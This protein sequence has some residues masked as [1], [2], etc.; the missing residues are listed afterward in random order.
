MKFIFR[1]GKRLLKVVFTQSSCDE[2]KLLGANIDAVKEM[3]KHD[4]QIDEMTF[5]SKLNHKI[6]VFELECAK[7]INELSIET[8]IVDFAGR[9]PFVLIWQEF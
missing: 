7:D 1:Q 3:P 5:I 6:Y 4:F 2:V 9:Y 8:N